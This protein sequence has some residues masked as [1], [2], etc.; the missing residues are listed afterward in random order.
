MLIEKILQEK[1]LQARRLCLTDAN[2]CGFRAG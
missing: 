2:G 1:H